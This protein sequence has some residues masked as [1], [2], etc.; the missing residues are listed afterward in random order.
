MFALMCMV[1]WH[2]KDICGM[3]TVPAHVFTVHGLSLWDAGV[4]CVDVFDVWW[5]KILT[6]TFKIVTDMEIDSH[7]PSLYFD[8]DATT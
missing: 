7:K 8:N 3:P 1:N 2:I 4:Y 6:C 5:S